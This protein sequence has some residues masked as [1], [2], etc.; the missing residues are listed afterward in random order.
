MKLA[1]IFVCECGGNISEIVDLSY[2]ERTFREEGLP[3]LRH[4]FLCSPEG[5]SL[6]RQEARN[7][8]AILV[9]ACSP[10]LHGETFQRILRE[11]GV[12]R[13]HI[14]ALREEVAWSTIGNPTEKALKLLRAGWRVLREMEEIPRYILKPV[15]VLLIIGGG[16]A[17]ITSALKA[18]E[19]GLEV[20]LVEREPFLGGKTLYV[21][22]LY[23]RLECASCVFSPLLSAIARARGVKIYTQARILNL[24]GF[25]GNFEVDLE[26]RPRYVQMDRCNGCGKCI[27]ACPLDPPAINW[28]VPHPVPRVPVINPFRCLRFKN[29]HCRRCERTCAS[30]A[31]NFEEGWSRRTVRAGGIIVATGFRP[32]PVERIAHYGYKR[33]DGVFTLF[34]LEKKFCVGESPLPTGSKPPRRAAFVHCAGSR[35]RYHLPYCSEICCGLALKLSLRLKE[36]FPG[37]EIWHFYQD[38][39]LKGPEG[40]SLWR[41][42]LSRG[43]RFVRGRVADISEVPWHPDQKGGLTIEVEDTLALKKLR[44][45]MDIVVLVP[46]FMPEL[47]AGELA[48]LLGLCMGES[49]FFEAREPKTH[50]AETVRQGIWLAGACA[51]PRD[52]SETIASAEAAALEAIRFLTQP[53]ISLTPF[54]LK[55]EESLCGGCYLCLESCPFKAL[56]PGPQGLRILHQLCT[57]CGI[58]V[59][60][61]PSGA[62]HLSGI[63]RMSSVME[64]L[65]T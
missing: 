33:L 10:D 42:A 3:V 19:A 47:G 59:S 22:R 26:I 15:P 40:E 16:A 34:D 44:L 18:S 48:A 49:G 43:I 36:I 37:L 38:L 52:L 62:L 27:E 2:L 20:V 39:R 9:G 55:V 1:K 12:K 24:S 29:H 32:Y 23:P 61:C 11:I 25:A 7:C 4:P 8:P 13:F 46:G 50:P 65:L 14:V 63:P 54:R 45:D 58:C 57:G 41:E 21:D 53:E 51:G 31:V 64:V 30:K 60:A 17:G 28:P 6:L 35:D 56:A 5:Q